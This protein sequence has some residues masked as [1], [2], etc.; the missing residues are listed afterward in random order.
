MST[1]SCV[2]QLL[3]TLGWEL[4]W[5][6]GWSLS[7]H[8]HVWLVQS[9]QWCMEWRF[10]GT[11][12]QKWFQTYFLSCSSLGPSKKCQMNSLFSA[13]L[14]PTGTMQLASGR[15][16]RRRRYVPLPYFQ[17]P[18]FSR[19]LFPSLDWGSWGSKQSA[20]FSLLLIHLR[21]RLAAVSEEKIV[22]VGMKG[23]WGVSFD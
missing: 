2:S 9:G 15:V 10:D 12:R 5:D 23:E 1:V 22:L 21:T 3:R 13:S 8:Y 17:S 11:E 20:L 4:P 14:K 6:T 18:V 7:P 19:A 16:R